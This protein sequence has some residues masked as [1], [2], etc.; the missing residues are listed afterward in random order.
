VTVPSDYD[1]D[2]LGQVFTPPA[3]V[4]AMLLLVRNRGRVLEPA[5]GDGAF[6]RHFPSAL[7]IEIDNKNASGDATFLGH[8]LLRQALSQN[9]GGSCLSHTT[10]QASNGKNLGHY[11]PLTPIDFN[12]QSV[13]SHCVVNWSHQ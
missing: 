12:V 11:S 8:K 3:V 2:R 7:G 9:T 1:V 10:L 6:L 13:S 5:C 4:E